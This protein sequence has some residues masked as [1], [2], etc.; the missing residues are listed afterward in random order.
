[1]WKTC[2]TIIKTESLWFFLFYPLILLPLPLGYAVCN[3]GGR[4]N[5]FLNFLF[6]TH[7]YALCSSCGNELLAAQIWLEPCEREGQGILKGLEIWIWFLSISSHRCYDEKKKKLT[8]YLYFFS[9]ILM[10]VGIYLFFIKIRV[11]MPHH[12]FVLLSWWLQQ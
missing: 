3:D 7:N 10:W 4:D 6:L 2:T 11:G 12:H 8:W 9:L 1:M 5:R